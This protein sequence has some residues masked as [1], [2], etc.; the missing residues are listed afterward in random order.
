MGHRL[1]RTRLL[2]ALPTAFCLAMALLPRADARS[3][4]SRS[5]GA[6][7]LAEPAAAD[8][9]SVEAHPRALD[10]AAERALALMQRDPEAGL[11]LAREGLEVARRIGY[12][13]GEAALNRAAGANLNVLGRNEASLVYY[14]EALRIFERLEDRI[15]QIQTLRSIG[16][17]Y[18]DMDRPAEALERYLE[19]LRLAEPAGDALELAKT[20]ANIGNVHYRTGNLAAAVPYQ[21]RALEA[22]EGADFELGIAGVALNLGAIHRQLAIEDPERAAQAWQLG[23]AALERSVAAFR[24]LAIPRGVANALG[25]LASLE[26]DAGN[27]DR[28]IER[29]REAVA[30]RREIG[31]RYNLAI[32][33]RRLAEML[34]ETGDFDS[35]RQ[36][37]EE[38]E[39]VAEG[40]D[41]VGSLADILAGRARLEEAAGE[42]ALALAYLNRLRDLER[43]QATR[44]TQERLARL[45]AE[46][47]AERAEQELALL[48][49]ERT[50]DELQLERTRTMRNALVVG[51]A[52]LVLLL[53]LAVSRYRLSQQAARQL[54]TVARTDPLTGLANRRGFADAIEREIARATRSGVPFALAAIDLD[55]FKRVNDRY[56]HDAG[57]AVLR[58]I[59]RRMVATVRGNDLVA[60]WGG[61]EFLVLLPDT[62]RP[63]AVLLGEELRGLVC[64]APVRIGAIEISVSITVGISVFAMGMTLDACLREADQALLQGKQAGR[65]RVVAAS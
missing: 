36:A 14:A 17:S 41:T 12:P 34:A 5:A 59:A 20:L 49:Q 43:Q 6:S 62:D 53:V 8:Q 15:A 61:E 3:D 32:G 25:T 58:E 63:G 26:Y 33:L 42:F 54:A 22:F 21:Q 46:Y 10:D 39:V 4:P 23:R 47:V 31:D 40:A 28:G 24:S 45:E 51:A 64:G 9:A 55:H 56:G 11:A 13:R 7:G 37:L 60:R 57:D 19:A 18:Y 16:V 35:A 1:A 44:E 48:R 65:N 50:I 29:M 30:L 27:V 38:G 52:L 2:V